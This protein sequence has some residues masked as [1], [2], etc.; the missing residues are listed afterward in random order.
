[1]AQAGRARVRP[2]QWP[3]SW[4]G[5]D[6]GTPGWR[7]RRGRALHQG[8]GRQAWSVWMI[9]D[10]FRNVSE[11]VTATAIFGKPGAEHTAFPVEFPVLRRL[12]EILK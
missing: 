1:M 11:V 8:G 5:I 10:R 2:E 12:L 4:K 6:P 3:R 7:V 9:F